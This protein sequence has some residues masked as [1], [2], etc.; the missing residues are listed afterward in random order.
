MDFEHWKKHAGGAHRWTTERA[1]ECGIMNGLRKREGVGG[2]PIEPGGHVDTARAAGLSTYILGLIHFRLGDY[3]QAVAKFHE[4]VT[5]CG[6]VDALEEMFAWSVTVFALDF[7]HEP[8]RTVI[9]AAYQQLG[10]P[11]PQF[12]RGAQPESRQ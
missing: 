7:E 5:R 3:E 12:C 1:R 4:A 8:V 6:G 10:R 9:E 2:G 11:A